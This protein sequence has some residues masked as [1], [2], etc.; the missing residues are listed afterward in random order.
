M[1]NI[2]GPTMD[3]ILAMGVKMKLAEAMA[4][5]EREDVVGEQK[6][7]NKTNSLTSRCTVATTI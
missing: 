3:F 5:T 1:T 4:S 7:L 2:V 6:A